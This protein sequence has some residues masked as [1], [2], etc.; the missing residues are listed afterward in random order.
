[1]DSLFGLVSQDGFP[2]SLGPDPGVAP[3]A[4]LFLSTWS[5]PAVSRPAC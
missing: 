5:A 2:R 1:M 3:G 4:V